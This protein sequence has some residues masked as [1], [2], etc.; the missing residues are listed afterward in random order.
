MSENKLP[1]IFQT[2]RL[3]YTLVPLSLILIPLIGIMF[4]FNFADDPTI[5]S[6]LIVPLVAATF[7][8]IGIIITVYVV[9]KM[10]Q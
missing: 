9:L 5:P 6:P 1:H 4:F 2:G 7:I 8:A 3:N 10:K